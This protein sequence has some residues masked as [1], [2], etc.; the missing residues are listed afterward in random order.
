M[1][2]LHL[3][4]MHGGFV[5]TTFAALVYFHYVK[6][7]ELKQVINVCAFGTFLGVLATSAFYYSYLAFSFVMAGFIVYALH[8]KHFSEATEI[9][10]NTMRSV[11]IGL[12]IGCTSYTG[13][14]MC[15]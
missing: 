15:I 1:H 6:K 7:M 11:V 14:M 10:Q 3:A 12:V 4:I 13:C 2:D 5:I 9:N 8:L